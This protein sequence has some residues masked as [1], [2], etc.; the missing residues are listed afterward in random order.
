MN[1]CTFIGNVGKDA[2]L[3]QAGNSQVCKFS[4][5]NTTGFGDKKATIWISCSLW[6]K[7]GQSLSQYLVKGTK[8]L[9]IGELSEIEYNNKTYLNLN[10]N[11]IEMLGER[12]QGQQGQQGQQ[13]YNQQEQSGQ[14]QPQYA[15][16]GQQSQSE[17]NPFDTING[18][19]F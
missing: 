1:S 3:A 4:I 13:Q 9:V 2:E 15:Q 10:V 6:G 18:N 11:Q 7:R 17:F 19:P 8:V 14:G 16:P 5:A 12:Q